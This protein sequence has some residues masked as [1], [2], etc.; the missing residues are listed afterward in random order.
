MKRFGPEA[1]ISATRSMLVEQPAEPKGYVTAV[2]QREAGQRKP[3]Q[4]N[5]QEALEQRNLAAA[6]RFAMGA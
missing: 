5:R 2:C 4:I 3:E 1:V 6:E